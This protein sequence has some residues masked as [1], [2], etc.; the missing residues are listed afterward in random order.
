MKNLLGARESDDCWPLKRQDDKFH[1]RPSSSA[2][3]LFVQYDLISL[4]RLSGRRTKNTNCTLSDHVSAPGSLQDLSTR[5]SGA[6]RVR[7]LIEALRDFPSMTAMGQKC[8]NGFGCRSAKV[9]ASTW[10][11]SCH[12]RSFRRQDVTSILDDTT[13]A[14][15]SIPP[16][17]CAQCRGCRPRIRSKPCFMAAKR[18]SIEGSNSVSVKM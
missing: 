1:R 15:S 3:S 14:V 8:P 2:S 13:S 4:S 17:V 10:A 16:L 11:G 5:L 6:A 7:N 12:K 9:P 18:S